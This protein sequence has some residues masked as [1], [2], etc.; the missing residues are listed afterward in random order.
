MYTYTAYLLWIHITHRC[1]KSS[2]SCVK[3]FKNLYIIWIK[4]EI[5]KWEIGFDSF[6]ICTSR[7]PYEFLLYEKSKYNLTIGSAMFLGY[8]CYSF[9]GEGIKRITV[10]TILLLTCKYT[11]LLSTYE[12]NTNNFSHAIRA[13][14]YSFDTHQVVICTPLS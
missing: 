14:L 10:T 11:I 6:C 13:I 12:Y 1:S 2:S 7:N 8:F 3:A 4:W 9:I 5:K